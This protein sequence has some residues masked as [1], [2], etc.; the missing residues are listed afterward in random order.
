MLTYIPSKSFRLHLRFMNKQL[1]TET[2]RERVGDREEDSSCSTAQNFT[3][4]LIGLSHN[5]PLCK[6]PFIS[7]PSLLLSLCPANLVPWAPNTNSFWLHRCGNRKQRTSASSAHVKTIYVSPSSSSIFV[8]LTVRQ[9]LRVCVCVW[10]R[11]VS[12][13]VCVW[14]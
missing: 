7:H 5:L 14:S 13:C 12:L 6:S 9:V 10:L 11:R 8:D 3:H 2:E 4:V 1:E